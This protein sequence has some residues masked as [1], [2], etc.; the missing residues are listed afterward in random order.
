MADIINTHDKMLKLFKR[1]TG[2]M[3]FK[4]KSYIQGKINQTNYQYNKVDKKVDDALKKTQNVAKNKFNTNVVRPI[5]K[6]M[7][8]TK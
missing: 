5:Q 3:Q 7:G 6:F 1:K 2:S 8:S 4:A